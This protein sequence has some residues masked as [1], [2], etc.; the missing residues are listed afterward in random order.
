MVKQD[1]SINYNHLFMIIIFFIGIVLFSVAW[2]IDE[3]LQNTQCTSTSLK[4]SNKLVLC[5]GTILILFSLSFFSCSVYCDKTFDTGPS[6]LI[7]IASIFVLGILLV[8]MGSII[9][10]NSINTCVNSGSPTTIW[11]LGIIL[12][13]IS[14]T[15]FFMKFKNTK[16]H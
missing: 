6:L 8:I 4:T 1:E 9:S 12:V 14:L 10:T 16:K 11:G 15:Y 2:N 7:H 5:I 3:K 13:L